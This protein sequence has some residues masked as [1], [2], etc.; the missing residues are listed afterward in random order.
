MLCRSQTSSS[1]WRTP[2]VLS[3]SLL[4]SQTLILR[5][6]RLTQPRI[7]I[8][9]LKTVL[10]ALY[11]N[12]RRLLSCSM[13]HVRTLFSCSMLHDS[14]L[15]S[16]SML[17]ESILL[18]AVLCSMIQYYLAV[19]CSVY[20]HCFAVLCCVCKLC[21]VFSLQ[22]NEAGV[23]GSCWN[24]KAICCVYYLLTT[25]LCHRLQ[26]AVC[27]IYLLLV[28]VTASNVLLLYHQILPA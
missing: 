25:S 4:R 11:G 14:I 5:G 27:I 22:C 17:H 18:I 6:L 15:F 20:K 8:I 28:S 1:S 9:W 16:Y 26:S 19:L 23:C 12:I 2:S 7:F 24:I 3:H 21:R 13:L 10:T